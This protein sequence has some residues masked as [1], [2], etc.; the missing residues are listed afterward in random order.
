MS[1]SGLTIVGFWLFS[2]SLVHISMILLR[3]P[4]SCV[5][6]KHP[7]GLHLLWSSATAVNAVLPCAMLI[8]GSGAVEVLF[9]S[10]A[11]ITTARQLH[12]LPP[13]A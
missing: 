2:F 1:L 10:L 12:S 5:V 3:Y 4:K 6:D 7:K 11:L 9:T 8:E 13:L